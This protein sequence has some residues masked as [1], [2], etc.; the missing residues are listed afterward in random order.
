MAHGR[1]QA[2]GQI[3]AV[4]AG[5]QHS[6]SNTGSELHHSSWQCQILNPLSKTRDWTCVFMDTSQVHYCWAMVRMPYLIFEKCQS[7]E[8]KLWKVVH[9]NTNSGCVII[10]LCGIIFC[11]VFLQQACITFIIRKKSYHN[12]ENWN[13][14]HQG[15]HSWFHSL[16]E[17]IGC[18]RK[19]G[20]T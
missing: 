12:C 3:G 10:E 1:S 4:A 16:G 5:L 20:S 9:W 13:H 18:Q 15:Q 19:A 17:A 7:T 8:E 11:F 6:H 2:S 14:F